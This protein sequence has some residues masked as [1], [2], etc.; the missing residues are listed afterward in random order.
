[1]DDTAEDSARAV[2]GILAT[3]I[4]ATLAARARS[5]VLHGSLAAGGFR[6]GRS[7]VDLLVVVEVESR[8]G[9]SPDLPAELSMARADGRSLWGA[10]PRDVIA[11]V[12]AE[13]IVDRGRYW[14]TRWQSLTAD[15]A[16]AA[17]MVLT[18]CRIWHFA[19]LGSHTSKPRAAAWAIQQGATLPAIRQ[20]LHRYETD[21]AAPIAADD[22]AEVLATVLRRIG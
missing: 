4:V 14:L 22:V 6:P 13:W 1:V 5:V 19:E 8:A 21:P 16:N 9:S 3:S 11:P 20:A 10:Q 12:P 17:F 15:T 2:A 18:A 7:D